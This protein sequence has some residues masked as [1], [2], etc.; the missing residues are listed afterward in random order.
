[1][2]MSLHVVVGGGVVVVLFCSVFFFFVVLEG[3]AEKWRERCDRECALC[4]CSLPRIMTR[5]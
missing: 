3:V 1:M 2:C 5:T 4:S